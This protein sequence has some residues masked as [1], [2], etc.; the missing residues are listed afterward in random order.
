MVNP[1][2]VNKGDSSYCI[3]KK[4]NSLNWHRRKNDLLKSKIALII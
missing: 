3:G 1:I 2:R 4:M